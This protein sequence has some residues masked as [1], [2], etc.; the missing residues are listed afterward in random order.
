[1]LL[2]YNIEVKTEYARLE[3]VYTP[4]N[5]GKQKNL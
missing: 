1:M 5:I 4:F 2:I 3:S